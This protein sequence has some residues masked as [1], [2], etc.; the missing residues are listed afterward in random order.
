MITYSEAKELLKE[1]TL[2]FKTE[3]ISID[4]AL[5]RVLAQDIIADR[6][7]PP[8]NRSAMD[9]YVVN[10][11]WFKA[12]D[13]KKCS[14]QGTC[15]AG[16]EY[17]K[18]ID[19]TKALKIMTGAP[20][21]NG[22]DA[23]IR[24]EDSEPSCDT[25]SFNITTLNPF[26]N[27]AKQGEDA[28][29]GQVVIEKNKTIDLGN[30]GLLATVGSSNIEVYKQPSISIITT[31]T[32]IKNVTDDVENHQIRNSNVYN[33]INGLKKVGLD[34]AF[35]CH[36]PDDQ[37]A[38]NEAIVKGLNSDILILTGGVSMGDADFVPQLLRENG[39][40]QIFHKIAMKPGKP[41]WFGKSNQTAVFGLPGNPLSAANC[42]QLIVKPYLDYCHNKNATQN[43]VK[44]IADHEIKAGRIDRFF[45][46]KLNEGLLSVNNFNGSGDILAQEGTLGIAYLKKGKDYTKGSQIDC[47]FV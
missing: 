27:I 22:L 25:V 12:I 41:V 24:V 35:Q 38:L 14:I 37:K 7:Y 4:Q 20:V 6:D 45:P 34:V 18:E 39:V 26:T 10:T 42:L 31:G 30:I 32:E 46:F 8:F 33:L 23:I 21:P 1:N 19:Q 3:V 43:W 2:T 9:G 16:E 47:L 5:G 13:Q 40:E 11:E 17:L 36:I 28:K 44:L 29:K 15:F